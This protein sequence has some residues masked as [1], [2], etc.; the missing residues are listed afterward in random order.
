MIALRLLYGSMPPFAPIAA[1]GREE[2]EAA[3]VKF[4]LTAVMRQERTI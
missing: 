4:H 3:M 1:N 2:P